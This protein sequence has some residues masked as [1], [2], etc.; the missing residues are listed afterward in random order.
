[1]R[2]TFEG[3][4][5]LDF[6]AFKAVKNKL[7]EA[8]QVPV[9]TKVTTLV[10][11]QKLN[12]LVQETQVTVQEENSWLIS[13]LVNIPNDTFYN[14]YVITD[15]KFKRLYNHVSGSVYAPKPGQEKVVY[16]VDIDLEFP[17]PTKWNQE[18]I[19]YLLEGGYLVEEDGEYYGI[20]K[21]EF[22]ATHSLI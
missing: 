9:G 10:Y 4:R 6:P 22:E 2:V 21:Y 14:E 20:N 17:Y 16:R 8:K 18:G 7:V 12:K 5:K 3:I 1:M 19:F 13:Q 11:D 15:E